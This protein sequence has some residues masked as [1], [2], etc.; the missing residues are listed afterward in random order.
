MIQPLLL[1]A[2]LINAVL[3]SKAIPD[4]W[5]WMNREGSDFFLLA[6]TIYGP[7]LLLLTN[8]DLALPSRGYSTDPFRFYKILLRDPLV[9]WVA[10]KNFT[11]K[12]CSSYMILVSIIFLGV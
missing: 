3:S 1:G 11:Y 6:K 7:R 8:F 10:Q 12:S 2:S 9:G 4:F 5:I